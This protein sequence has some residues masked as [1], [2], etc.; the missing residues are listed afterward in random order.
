[1]QAYI[2]RIPHCLAFEQIS[3]YCIGLL[4]DFENNPRTFAKLV[5]L[6]W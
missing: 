2:L 4:T 5:A 1:M 6:K 3:Q